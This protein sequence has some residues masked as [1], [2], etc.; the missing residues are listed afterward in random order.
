MFSEGFDAIIK[1]DNGSDAAVLTSKCGVTGEESSW[2][3]SKS[4]KHFAKDF[5]SSIKKYVKMFPKVYIFL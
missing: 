2:L 1:G 3:M 4:R 5:S